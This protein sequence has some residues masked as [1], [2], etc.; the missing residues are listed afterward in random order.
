MQGSS[1]THVTD[2]G[3]LTPL[4]TLPTVNEKQGELSIEHSHT[5]RRCSVT[6]TDGRE[7]SQT[8][9]KAFGIG[10]EP[11][12]G[13]GRNCSSESSKDSKGSDEFHDKQRRTKGPDREQGGMDV[14]K[15]EL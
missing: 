15:S 9:C 2:A 11:I 3:R 10:T 7:R 5:I 8:R 6:T 14:N 12:R 1:V 4:T 13:Y